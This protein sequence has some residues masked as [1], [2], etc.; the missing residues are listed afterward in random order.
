M[1]YIY[2]DAL[3]EM[4]IGQLAQ[5]E[6]TTN[7]SLD[8]PTYKRVKMDERTLEVVIDCLEAGLD[9]YEDDDE[10]VENLTRIIDFLKE[11]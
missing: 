6:E 11:E 1:K 3:D 8:E 9:A 4:A 2:N 5:Y 7:T 10:A